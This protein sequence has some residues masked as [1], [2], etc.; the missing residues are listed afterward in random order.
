MFDVF[1][2]TYTYYNLLRCV[3]REYS[4]TSVTMKN[5]S[6]YVTREYTTTNDE[7]YSIYVTRKYT[8]ISICTTR[9]YTT[10]ND[11]KLLDLRDAK[12]RGEVKVCLNF[13]L[14]AITKKSFLIF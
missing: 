10:T 7:K 8:T 6:I 12:S 9:E 5:Y 11:E 4:M 2:L 13:N 1:V 3:R 14:A